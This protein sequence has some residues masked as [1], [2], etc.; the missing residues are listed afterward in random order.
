MMTNRESALRTSYLIP[1]TS[2]LK[3]F[4]L[5]ELLVVIAI[6]A[7]LA[8]ML[9]PALGKVK[10][11]A[12]NASCLNNMKQCGLGILQYA[13][14]HDDWLPPPWNRF[15]WS[16][17][18]AY[19]LNLKPQLPGVTDAD[20]QGKSLDHAFWLATD[21]MFICPVQDLTYGVNNTRPDTTARPVVGAT[22][23]RP[24]IF[25]AGEM[26]LINGKSGGWGT[27]NYDKVA[28]PH[29][30]KTTQILNDS[31]IMGECY[32]V[33]PIE[34]T[35]YDLLGP[36]PTPLSRG[37]W[38]KNLDTSVAPNGESVNYQRHA[39]TTNILF[40]DCHAEN[41]GRRP[42]DNYFRLE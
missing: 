12:T 1:H 34:G 2:Y 36:T 42:I 39:G 27:Y 8:G 29:S 23:Y 18:I 24:T 10:N 32:Y 30:K 14:A 33:P 6:I 37:F 13:G 11:T 40:P 22:T 20:R 7:I 9:L 25:E 15:Y 26:T 21:K 19:E 16:N 5:I 3:R 4:T 38:R 35:K 17:Y 31:I 41:I 28:Y